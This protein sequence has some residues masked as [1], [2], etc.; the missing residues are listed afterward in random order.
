VQRTVWAPEGEQLGRG[1]G[2]F[3]IDDAEG[4][5]MVLETF[6]D[7]TRRDG[8]RVLERRERAMDTPLFVRRVGRDA[9]V[10]VQVRRLGIVN[11]STRRCRFV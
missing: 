6:D 7:G 3:E 2:K 1:A 5:V 4:L 8:L 9:V 11:P 10:L